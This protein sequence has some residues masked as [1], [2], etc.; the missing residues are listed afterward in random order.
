[1][2]RISDGSAAA[3][4]SGAAWLS[5]GER[6]GGEERRCYADPGPFN[7][8]SSRLLC[9]GVVPIGGKRARVTIP[10]SLSLDLPQNP[11]QTGFTFA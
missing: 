10:V 11:V 5:V 6:R 1:M 3:V 2:S 7:V 9:V 4:W 8:A